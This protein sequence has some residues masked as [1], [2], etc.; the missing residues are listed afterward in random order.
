MIVLILFL[1][2]MSH[3]HDR[4]MSHTR[5]SYV[6]HMSHDRH[7]SCHT[8]ECSTLQLVSLIVF[9]LG[10]FYRIE[11]FTHIWMR[12]VAHVNESCHAHDMSH[13]WRIH[14]AHDMSHVMTHSCTR[15]MSRIRHVTRM[16][17]TSRTRHVTRHD[18]FVY[19]NRVT[20]TTCHVTNMNEL[21]HTYG[22]VMTHTWRRH[23]ISDGLEY[24]CSVDWNIVAMC[25][26]VLKCVA[27]CD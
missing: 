9:L 12:H 11:N 19:T 17:H 23:R 2:I 22:C 26:S 8:Y 1:D 24:S 10:M 21:C 13:V 20:H 16:S 6:T 7:R 14:H 27:V 15:I 25:C 5:Q 3:T 4:A 18:A